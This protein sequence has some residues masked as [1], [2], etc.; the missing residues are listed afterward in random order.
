MAKIKMKRFRLNEISTVDTPAQRDAVVTIMK[1]RDSELEDFN[2]W[3]GGGARE[4]S[5]NDDDSVTLE[6]RGEQRTFFRP[7]ADPEP[8][9]VKHL[10]GDLGWTPESE[11][12]VR[13]ILAGQTRELDAIVAERAGETVSKG[14]DKPM[15]KREAPD[16]NE[17]RKTAARP[18]RESQDDAFARRVVPTGRT[19]DHRLAARMSKSL[20]PSQALRKARLENPDQ[21]ARFQ[22]QPR[23]PH[24]ATAE[25]D[26][27][28]E[29]LAKRQQAARDFK[30]TVSEIKSR[31]RCTGSEAM[32]TARKEDPEGFAAYQAS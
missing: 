30:K 10:V 22:H 23:F 9:T 1:R 5:V 28:H 26:K 32:R 16:P 6:L 8:T 14:K 2:K 17:L 27:Q 4:V 24:I 25:E 18:R 20:T 21:Y 29:Q 31:D 13:K 19:M 15:K 3:M 7:E 11:A 12:L